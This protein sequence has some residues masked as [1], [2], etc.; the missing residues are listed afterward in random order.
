[1][2]RIPKSLP[3]RDGYLCESRF[4]RR[5]SRS[6]I[7]RLFSRSA[8][9]AQ[10]STARKPGTG[11]GPTAGLG[12]ELSEGWAAVGVGGKTAV[13]ENY[14]SEILS[15]FGHAQCGQNCDCRRGHRTLRMASSAAIH[16]ASRRRF[17]TLNSSHAG[18]GAGGF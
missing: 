12:E 16:G 8:S 6:K 1:M 9:V 5:E 10:R 2:V 11:P 15:E 14:G 13:S 4:G 17:D 18:V 3:L 7:K